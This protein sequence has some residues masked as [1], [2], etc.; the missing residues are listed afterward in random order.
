MY[1]FI[2]I[3]EYVLHVAQTQI[4][5]KC[6]ANIGKWLEALAENIQAGFLLVICWNLISWPVA[7]FHSWA[8]VLLP[9][10]NQHNMTNIEPTLSQR[11]RNNL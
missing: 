4:A 2:S 8:N 11:W 1:Q 5:E 10:W 7:K 9:M 3:N 6:W